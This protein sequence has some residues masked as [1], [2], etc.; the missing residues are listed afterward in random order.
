M[1]YT[2][3][4][5]GFTSTRK[6]DRTYTHAVLVKCSHQ[7]DLAEAERRARYAYGWQSEELAKRAAA[8]YAPS[9]YTT[10]A[11]EAARQ[12]F[13]EKSTAGGLEA[14]VAKARAKVTAAAAKALGVKPAQVPADF[15][16][17]YAAATWCGRPD[18][19]A[20]EAGKRPGSV[21]VAVEVR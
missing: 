15:D 6:S 9:L 16:T 19:A 4:H 11:R 3:T 8:D 2:A 18:L 1:N 13:L 21:I 12:A 7:A 14:Q 5:N 10:A 17:Y 20:K